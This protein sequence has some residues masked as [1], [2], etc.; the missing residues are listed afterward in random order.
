MTTEPRSIPA[1]VVTAAAA[2]ALVASCAIV[3]VA[4]AAPATPTVAGAP[5]AAICTSTLAKRHKFAAWLSN[6]IRRALAGRDSVVGLTVADPRLGLTCALDETAHFDAASVIKVTILSA[7][8][9]AR[10][11]PSHLTGSQK[12]LARLMITES[13]NNAA[14]ALWNEVG[15]AGMQRFLDRAGMRHTVLAYAW[16]LTQLTAQDELT[17]LRVL[18]TPGK[19]LSTASR[20]YVLGLMARVVPSQR[21]GVP[22]G[23][24]RGVTVSVKNGWLPYPTGRDWHINSIGAFYGRDVAYEIAILTSGNPSEADGIATVQAAA[25]VINRDIARG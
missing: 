24:P 12:S 17:L 8:L 10:G 23:A 25:R 22:D 2:G 9:L 14:T 16:G 7:L 4:S 11:G 6:G 19:V 3:G 1:T 15:T 13:D 18:T 21:W 5:A 20:H